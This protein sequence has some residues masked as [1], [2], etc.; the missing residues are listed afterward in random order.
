MPLRIPE[1]FSRRKRSATA[2]SSEVESDPSY[3]SMLYTS[4]SVNDTN[5]TSILF[6]DPP[7]DHDQRDHTTVTRILP[8]GGAT[9]TLVTFTSDTEPECQLYAEKLV[10]GT[11]IR[12][13]LVVHP[14]QLDSDMKMDLHVAWDAWVGRIK[15]RGDDGFDI[16]KENLLVMEGKGGWP[17]LLEYLKSG[18]ECNVTEDGAHRNI[19]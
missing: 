13:C 9:F 5:W 16:A 7:E 6:P 8:N 1:V 14:G 11:R 2:T 12:R 3:K 17:E 15:D 4:H 18:A 10:S 19:R